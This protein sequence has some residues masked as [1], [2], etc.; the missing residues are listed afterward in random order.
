MIGSPA[1]EAKPK[2]P[3]LPAAD[4][5]NPRVCEYST[6][7]RLKNVRRHSRLFEKRDSHVQ[8]PL[9]DLP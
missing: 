5:L 6:Q 7:T 8:I 3:V 4:A 2:P 9:G 1:T